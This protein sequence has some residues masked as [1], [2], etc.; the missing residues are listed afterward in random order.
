MKKRKLRTCHGSELGRH[1][2]AINVLRHLLESTLH[3][4]LVPQIVHPQQN[5]FTFAVERVLDTVE[6]DKVRIAERRRHSR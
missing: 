1:H 6:R 3:V 5:E 2:R 4:E